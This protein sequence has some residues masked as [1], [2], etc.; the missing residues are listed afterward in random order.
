[1]QRIQTAIS[2]S[3]FWT[4]Q[5]AVSVG[6]SKRTQRHGGHRVTQSP[7]RSGAQDAKAQRKKPLMNAN[8]TRDHSNF[9][10][11]NQ[12]IS[13]S[14]HSFIPSLPPFFS[15][16]FFVSFVSFVRGFC[17]LEKP[18]NCAQLFDVSVYQRFLPLLL[19]DFACHS[20]RQRTA[21][22]AG[23][24]VDDLIAPPGGCVGLAIHFL[25]ADCLGNGELDRADASS[26]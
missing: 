11:K 17:V 25:S 20:K 19:C 26:L 5:R 2:D 15:A 14:L 22:A 4:V 7:T 13:D 10:F 24:D 8:R 21:F 12:N 3:T 9:A 16:S 18:L 1:M 23:M 6:E